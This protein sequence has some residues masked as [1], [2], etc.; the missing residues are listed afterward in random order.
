MPASIKLQREHG[1]DLAVIFVESQGT[2][3]DDV[4]RF[5][6]KHKWLGTPAMWTSERPF[7]LSGSGLPKY[8]LLSADGKIIAEGN[9]VDKKART[10]IE[11][12]IKK[13]K[14][15]PEGTPKSLKKAWSNFGK[16]KVAKAIQEAEK[17]AAKGEEA[18]AAEEAIA[19]FE[20]R[21]GSRLARAT[22]LLDNGYA[23][24][25][26]RA[27]DAL[28]GELKGAGELHEQAIA[29]EARFSEE[30]VKAELDAC[31]VIDKTLEKLYADGR[32]EKLFVKL[33]RLAEKHAGTK[34][35]ERARRVAS[36]KP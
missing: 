19:E 27:V 2:K 9:H 1:D 29:L 22:W 18:E 12:E 6:L 35:A 31:K 11:E 15:A 28:V 36:L 23:V 17:V 24:Q 30:D 33:E 16:G 34:A 25:A 4:E 5:I 7:N 21:T 26:E 13:G 10:L 3:P 8:A 14:G 20:R 32:D